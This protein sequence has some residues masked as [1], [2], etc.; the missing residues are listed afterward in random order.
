M[1]SN[2]A[3]HSITEI[4]AQFQLTAVPFLTHDLRVTIANLK[5]ILS[6]A[7]IHS[8]YTAVWP[9]TYVPEILEQQ[10]GAFT[11]TPDL[12]FTPLSIGHG[13]P[14]LIHKQPPPHGPHGRTVS[15]VNPRHAAQSRSPLSSSR[16][17]RGQLGR[18]GRMTRVIVV[19]G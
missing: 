18:I 2:L 8:C 13:M 17:F 9:H 3:K 5:W 6:V 4:S 14:Y 15:Q 1:S 10:L 7:S 11:F 16:G 19:I 12:N